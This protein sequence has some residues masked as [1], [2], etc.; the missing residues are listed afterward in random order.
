V[1]ILEFREFLLNE[2]LRKLPAVVTDTDKLRREGAGKQSES[3][4]TKRAFGSGI[5]RRLMFS[6]Q[7]IW[8]KAP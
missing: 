3:H 2:G 6:G 7:G 1:H 5:S 4:S 8:L